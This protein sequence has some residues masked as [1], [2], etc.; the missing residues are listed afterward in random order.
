[1]PEGLQTK[2]Q[3]IKEREALRQLHRQAILASSL[4]EFKKSL[5]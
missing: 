3:E 5:G 4:E 1:V 2:L